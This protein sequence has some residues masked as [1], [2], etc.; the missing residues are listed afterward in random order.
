M[1]HLSTEIEIFLIKSR[2]K[3]ML[4][5]DLPIIVGAQIVQIICPNPVLLDLIL[6][7]LRTENSKEG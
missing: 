6:E 3:A 4:L 5:E 2:I 1:L 7:S